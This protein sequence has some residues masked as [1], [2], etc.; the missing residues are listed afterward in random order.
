M[1]VVLVVE[2]EPLIRM[3][4][5]AM[6]EEAGFD[7]V[8]AA[9][10]DDALQILECHPEIGIVLSDVS[11]PGSMDGLRLAKVIHDRWS[12][13]RLIVAS[14]KSLPEGASIPEGGVFLPKPYAYGDLAD[15]LVKAN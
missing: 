15:A 5:V 7:V 12:S 9:N 13:I 1:A 8:E 10:A 3:S 2:D 11:M 4:A 14:G 6:V